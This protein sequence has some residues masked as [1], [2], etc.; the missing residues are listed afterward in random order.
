MPLGRTLHWLFVSLP[1][2]SQ[3]VPLPI[4]AAKDS[5]PDRADRQCELD[6]VA[7]SVSRLAAPVTIRFGIACD[8]GD[9]RVVT[10]VPETTPSQIALIDEFLRLISARGG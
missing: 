10:V 6:S 7:N 9:E 5:L 8:F 2:R 3:K 4:E 1:F